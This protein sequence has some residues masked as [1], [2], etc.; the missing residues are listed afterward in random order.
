MNV[1]EAVRRAAAA[2]EAIA[3]ELRRLNATQAA[4]A[5]DVK[6]L[7]DANGPPPVTGLKVDP[8]QPTAH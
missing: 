7:A 6:R 3:T 1:F 2:L 5:A 8:G 4:M